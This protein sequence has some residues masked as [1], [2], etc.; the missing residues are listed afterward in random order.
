MISDIDPDVFRNAQ[1]RGVDIET[2]D[3]NLRTLGPGVYR[4]DGYIAGVS[5]SNGEVSE[6]YDLRHP[7]TSPETR[8]RNERI[9]AHV[10]SGTGETVG[11]N[12][13]YDLDWLINGENYAVNGLYND[14]QYAEP[15]LDEYRRSYSLRA[16]A[17]NYGLEEKAT[18]LL[19][20]YCAEQGWVVTKEKSAAAYIWMM[21]A[22]VVRKYAA[23]DAQLAL[24]VHNLQTKEL[25]RQGMLELY[26]M[27]CDLMPL[28][29]QMRKNGVRLDM[30][31][32]KKTA[33]LVGE[34]HFN[35]A[36]KVYELA[37]YEF[38]IGS[39]AQLAKV[40]DKFG[41]PYPRKE[42]T[43][44]MVAKGLPG[45]PNL[46]KEALGPLRDKYEIIDLVMQW[47]HYNT[48]INMFMIP[49]LEYETNGRLHGQFHPLRN[50]DFGTV[51]GRFSASTP[52]LQQVPAMTDKEDDDDVDEN[53]KG[54]IV[55]RLFVPEDDHDWAKL[56]YSQVEYRITAHYAVGPGAEELRES[57]RNNPKTDYHKLIQDRTGFD[58][59]NT[60]R[61]NFG[62]SYGM[63][64]KTA[65]KKFGWTL[66][67][68]LMFMEVYHTSAPYLKATRNRVVQA[69]ERRGYIH[70]LLGRRARLHPS[71][72]THSFFNRLIQGSAADIMKAG[73]VAAYK[74]G[75]F[76]ELIPHLTVH[77]ELD[78]SV[79][80][81]KTGQEALL[82][83]KKT[84]EETIL[85]DVPLI[86][87]CHTGANWAEAD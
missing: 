34:E 69:A 62:A 46:D 86:V 44:S 45:N 67:E 73:M 14:V 84:M 70:T 30:H 81:T 15:L 1:K 37:G 85:L 60:K 3:P 55:R 27:E 53:L 24:Q 66:D 68:A 52:N 42:P 48:L 35:A 63:G 41:I 31:R 11:A 78:V 28:L 26:R 29:L 83:L 4:K 58:R 57:Y 19:E 65:A 21:P 5:F 20:A 75:L 2:K 8:E 23:T 51:S 74:Q 22:E 13:M 17:N 9:I 80:R 10:L 38:N 36:E 12:Y 47:K 79:P 40:L 6:Y 59:R 49:Y 61:L 87:D 33:M 82:A 16:L 72:A 77:D 43:E 7:D 76:K 32:L 50:D 54:Q 71:R 25:E 64:Y 18:A 56:D 39:S